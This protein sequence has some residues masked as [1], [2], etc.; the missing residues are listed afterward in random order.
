MRL[1][2]LASQG[3]EHTGVGQRRVALDLG[4]GQNLLEEF[5]SLGGV[6]LVGRR[7]LLASEL[8]ESG[9]H[10]DTAPGALPVD[11]NLFTLSGVVLGLV[12]AVDVLDETGNQL[13]GHAHEVVHISVGHIELESGEFGVVGEINA[14]VT[15]LTSHFVDSVETTNNKHLEVQLRGDTQVHVHVEVVVVGDEGLGSGTASNDVEHGGLDRDEVTVV[16]PATDIRVNLGT[17]DKDLAGLVIHHQVEVSLTETLLRVL[18][19]VVVVGDLVQAGRQ[20]N[21]FRGGNRQLTRE[22]AAALLV[23]GVGTGG[24]TTDT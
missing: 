23:L 10:L 3:I 19:A 2:E 24:M 15:E 22:V 1:K 20:E 16:E 12:R 21:D 9:N 6:K 11:L 18:E 17:S 13:L 14:L 8:L 4:L 7:E 5:T